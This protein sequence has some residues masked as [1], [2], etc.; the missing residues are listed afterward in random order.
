MQH[1]LPDAGAYATL[2]DNHS[3][4]GEEQQTCQRGNGSS[5]IIPGQ[6]PFC[7]HLKFLTQGLGHA[8]T[9]TAGD[10]IFV[11]HPAF[12]TMLSDN[13]RVHVPQIWL[14]S[15]RRMDSHC[16][17]SNC[18]IQQATTCSAL[19]A[20]RRTSYGNRMRHLPFVYGTSLIAMT[21]LA[22][23]SGSHCSDQ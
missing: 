17:P 14:T 1:A 3:A 18:V 4:Q 11:Q 19:C 2:A 8:C 7:L 10:N 5:V 20:C 21:T 9:P 13:S 15:D 12:C 16:Q 23:P 6:L 22:A